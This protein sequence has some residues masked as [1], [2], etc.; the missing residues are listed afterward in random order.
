MTQFRQSSA[1]VASTP[2]AW[3]RRLS[4]LW[5]CL[6]LVVWAGCDDLLT[7]EDEDI[8][9]P[10]NL[11]TS[12][13]LE[14]RRTGAFAD[15]A[16]AYGGNPSQ[17]NSEGQILVS[18]LFADEFKST[19]TDPT[20]I[21]ADARRV[22]TD[23][24][25]L[26]GYYAALHR[27]RRAAE[28]TAEVFQASDAA[29]NVDRTT[30]EMLNLAGYTY[31]FFAENY[32]SGVP[33]SRLTETGE[34]EYAEPSTT[35]ETLARASTRFEEALGATQSA[36][37]TELAHLARVGNGRALLNLGQFSAAASAVEGV[38]TDFRYDIRYSSN[39]QRQQNGVWAE[40]IEME[41]WSVVNAEGGG[42]DYLDA[43]VEGDPRTPW[44]IAPD[45]A[46][47]TPT[48]GLQ[49]YQRLY[50]SPSA[51]IPLATGVEARLI[52]AEAALQ[53]GD[54]A[55]FE[56]LH[57]ALRATLDDADVGTISV[58]TMSSE[59]LV[60][61]HFRERAFWMWLTGH[62]MGDMRRLVRQYQRSP[63]DV[64]PSGEYPRTQF[65]TYG[66]DVT[67]PIPFQETNNPHF[68]SCLDRDA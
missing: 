40:N 67:L 16:V 22:R 18:G 24:Q 11:D 59:E 42:L 33:F 15:F 2:G 20:R 25:N 46:G 43:H 53:G 4:P 36:G 44:V 56:D 19:D 64:F 12:A 68:T 6:S 41:R 48:A 8:V 21:E 14:A 29:Q 57:N 45:S 34:I 35:E 63:S 32:C 9:Q 7:V 30:A 10:E 38:P 62:R 51:S 47:F 58:D 31:L 49:F 52:E 66:D 60:D 17:N 3:R 54:E 23:N 27:A 5:L 13:G 65:S 50:E 28:A 1:P 55:T 39:T 61:F 37:S 26:S